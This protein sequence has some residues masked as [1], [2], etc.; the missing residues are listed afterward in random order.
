MRS[1]A[2]MTTLAL[3]LGAA[4]ASASPVVGGAALIAVPDG[5]ATAI[6]HKPGHH[7][8][9]PWA[10][11]RDRRDFDQDRD[12]DSYRE[13]YRDSYRDYDEERPR[14]RRQVCRTTYREVYDR[15]EDEY[16]RRPVRVCRSEY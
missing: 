14:Y 11:G 6:H 13:S 7:G 16:V 5:V 1:F 3:V 2:A 10:Q 8:G 4:G 15:Y 12:R 9:P